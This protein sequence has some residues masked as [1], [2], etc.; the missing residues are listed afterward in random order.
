M[1]SKIGCS[2]SASIVRLLVLTEVE[3]EDRGLN[4]CQKE[5]PGRN[6]K[7]GHPSTGREVNTGLRGGFRDSVAL[8]STTRV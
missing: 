6:E 4:V 3:V 8:S 2:D 7:K 1:T 5:C